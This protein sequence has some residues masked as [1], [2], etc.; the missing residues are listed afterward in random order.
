MVSGPGGT[1]GGRPCSSSSDPTLGTGSRNRSDR[2]LVFRELPGIR[3]W[4]WSDI[5]W[6]WC[7]D[8]GRSVLHGLSGGTD[9]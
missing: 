1:N 4:D 5:E 7:C 8:T 2:V 3:E 6:D 9:Y